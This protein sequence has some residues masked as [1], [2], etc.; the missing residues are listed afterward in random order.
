MVH[1]G[2]RFQQQQS[3]DKILWHICGSSKKKSFAKR[4]KEI[5][6]Q[7][8]SV[9]CPNYVEHLVNQKM[10]IENKIKQDYSYVL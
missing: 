1:N 9:R 8:Y 5:Q 2:K 6:S 3:L 7:S 10:N 4:E